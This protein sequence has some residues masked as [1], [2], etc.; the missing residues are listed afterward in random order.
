[1]DPSLFTVPAFEA[2]L[3]SAVACFQEDPPQE[4]KDAA[5]CVVDTSS[6][7]TLILPELS[8]EKIVQQQSKGKMRQLAFGGVG[9]MTPSAEDR[10]LVSGQQEA[11]ER[12]LELAKDLAR[13]FDEFQV[14]TL[15]V[16][17]LREY[18]IHSSHFTPLEYEVNGRVILRCH[19]YALRG[20][21]SLLTHEFTF[22]GIR[23]PQQH[24]DGASFW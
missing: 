2:V 6:Q 5:N 8:T 1:M 19:H 12:Q 9:Y 17:T 16:V 11:Y 24:R 18:M 15:F 7:R 3:A 14:I 23:L 4:V 22:E 10:D 20:L 13:T 21:S